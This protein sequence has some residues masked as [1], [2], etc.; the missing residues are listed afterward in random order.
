M[1]AGTVNSFSISIY[2]PGF[3]ERTPAHALPR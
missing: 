3:R 1:G 2:P